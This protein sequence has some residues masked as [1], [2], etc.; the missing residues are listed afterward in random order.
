M[1]YR[2]LQIIRG[3]NRKRLLG[4]IQEKHTGIIIERIPSRPS[5]HDRTTSCPTNETIFI[6]NHEGGLVGDVVA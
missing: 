4:E 3:G 2:F 6:L 1:S 5:K